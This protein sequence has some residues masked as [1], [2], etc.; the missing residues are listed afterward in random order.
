M[1][2]IRIITNLRKTDFYIEYIFMNG[3]C[4][5]F[6]IFLK[7]F[8]PNAKPQINSKRNHIVTEI[9]GNIYDIKGC[10]KK[11]G[12]TYL[13]KADLEMVQSWSFRKNNLLKITEC[14]FCE[15]PICV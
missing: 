6:Y 9:N 11:E 1:N 14:P 3:G 2:P 13:N 15:E 10:V 8:F 12:Y 4:Y 5:Q 7:V